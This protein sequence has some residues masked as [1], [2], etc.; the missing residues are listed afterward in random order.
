MKA[1]N[2]DP[3]LF[4]EFDDNLRDAFQRETELFLESQT[5]DD[6]PLEEMLT[7][8][9]TFV[10]ERL[11]RFYG[12]RNVY[13]SHFRRVELTDPHRAGLLG[14]GSILTVTSYS[15]RTSP[16][17]RGKY[18]LENIFGAPPPPPPPNVPPL[19]ET[20][21]GEQPMASMRERM[22][23]HRQNAVCASCHMRMDPLGFAL[24]NFDAIGKY[25]T[26]DGN[27]A[28][29]AS[30]VL[31]DGTKFS[32]PDEFR[33]ALLMHRD[34]FVRTFTEK[35][36]TYALGRAV[37]YYDMPALR[38]IIREA[39]PTNYR[40]SSL[41]LGIVTSKP[42]QMRQAQELATTEHQQ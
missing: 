39:A 37:Q 29:D 23:E 3:R 28:I 35:L 5:H 21:T 38:T 19:K 36:M 17:V 26:A 40:W 33:H 2:P 9:Y 25:R 32:G 30:G 14:Q 34:E 15:T 10:N 20:A 18:L 13:G 27:A 11:A 31:P 4:P 16:V 12:M 1:V 24:E 22:E 42:F 8:K 6:R 41:I 7:A